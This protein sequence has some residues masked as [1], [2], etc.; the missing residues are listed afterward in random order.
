[1]TWRRTPAT[2]PATT[3]RAIAT[4]Q[5]ALPQTQ[6]S[7][8]G[9]RQSRSRSPRVTTSVRSTQTTT[10]VHSLGA[11]PNV[12]DCLGTQRVIHRSLPS[13]VVH[14]VHAYLTGTGH[15]NLMC[16]LS[17]GGRFRPSG[18]GAGLPAPCDVRRPRALCIVSRSVQ[19]IENDAGA[20]ECESARLRS[21]IELNRALGESRQCYD[22]VS[23]RRSA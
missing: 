13:G 22:P 21:S 4:G 8:V 14:I 2:A 15:T 12:I 11:F 5:R 18:A 3:L 1:M 20:L 6:A 7:D 10:D 16:N 9:A 23:R 17:A 19:S